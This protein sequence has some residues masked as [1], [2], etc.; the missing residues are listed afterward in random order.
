MK[1]FRKDHYADFHDY[2]AYAENMDYDD[3]GT[4]YDYAT[5]TYEDDYDYDDEQLSDYEGDYADFGYELT[6]EA[7]AE[8]AEIQDLLDESVEGLSPEEAREFYGEFW[9]ALASAIPAVISAAPSIVK[10][11]GGLFKGKKRGRRPA[12]PRR[13]APRPAPRKAGGD[14]GIAMLNQKLDR[15]ISLLSQRK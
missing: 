8:I 14:S 5:D 9:G 15:L 2:P 1:K 3:E 11:I 6:E 7:E 4:D 12:P 13:T 10:G